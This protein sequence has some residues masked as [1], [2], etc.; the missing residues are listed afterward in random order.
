MEK[1]HNIIELLATI[2]A[3]SEHLTFCVINDIKEDFK[4]EAKQLLRLTEELN[5]EFNKT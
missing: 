5:K 1:N 2:Q 3:K 4:A